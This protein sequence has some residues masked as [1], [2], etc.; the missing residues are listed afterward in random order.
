MLYFL[1]EAQ[2]EQCCPGLVKVLCRSKE[3]PHRSHA[4]SQVV[5]VLQ[6]QVV[7]SHRTWNSRLE[8]IAAVFWGWMLHGMFGE[9]AV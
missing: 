7:S 3:A 4:G 6:D 5:S 8:E 9:K 1:G 2:T